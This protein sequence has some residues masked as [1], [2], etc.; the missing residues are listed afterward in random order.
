MNERVTPGPEPRGGPRRRTRRSNLYQR[1]SGR[2]TAYLRLNGEQVQKT[3]RTR[4]EALLWL[5]RMEQK[6][7]LQDEVVFPKKI[8][9]ADFAEEWL[10]DYARTNVSIRTFEGYEM[11]LRN[12]LIPYFGPLYLTQI[13][14]KK[15]DAFVADLGR[16]RPRV[17]G[18]PRTRP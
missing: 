12:H 4:D 7:V 3:F 17:P 18:A 11:S 9:F 14:R 10:R 15:I 6:R 13:T 5:A 8:T 1:S 16:R 2:W